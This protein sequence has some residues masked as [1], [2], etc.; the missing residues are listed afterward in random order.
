MWRC[1]LNS[2]DLNKNNKDGIRRRKRRTSA[3]K[4]HVNKCNP[5]RTRIVALR[6]CAPHDKADD[7][8][9]A[10]NGI[11]R[12]L[13][14]LEVVWLARAPLFLRGARKLILTTLPLVVVSL[15]LA[16]AVRSSTSAT[17]TKK[18][19][20]PSQLFKSG[21]WCLTAKYFAEAVASEP[22]LLTTCLKNVPIEQKN[23]RTALA[24][25]PQKQEPRRCEH[26][27]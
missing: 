10:Q 13:P 15:L 18:P 27:H 23:C 22:A 17:S 19:P 20:G 6:N 14:P 3:G 21:Q 16:T 5:P 7:T 26:L 24:T 8:G 11:A 1:R 2:Y 25:I 9:N 4:T 12:N